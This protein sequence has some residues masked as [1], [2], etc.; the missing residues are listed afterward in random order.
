MTLSKR[1]TAS[2]NPPRIRLCMIRGMIWRA[3][4]APEKFPAPALGGNFRTAAAG[5]VD[6]LVVVGQ[7]GQS[8]DARI[9]T[10]SGHSHYI[11]GEVACPS[12]SFAGAGRRGGDRGGHS[13]RGR[14]AVDGPARRRTKPARVVIDPNGRLPAHARVLRADGIRTLVVITARG[15]RLPERR[16]THC[17]CQRRT[18][19]SPAAIIAAL[20]DR[21]FRRILVEGGAERSRAFLLPAVSTGCISWSPPSS[22]AR[23]DRASPCLPYSGSRRHGGHARA[24]LARSAG[25]SRQIGLG[26]DKRR[27]AAGL[28][29]QRSARCGRPGED[30]DVTD[31]QASSGLAPDMRAPLGQPSSRSRRPTRSLAD[32]IQPGPVGEQRLLDGPIVGPNTQSERPCT[33]E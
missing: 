5:A 26:S 24:C 13:D 17:R 22:S 23:D 2:Q 30:V 33:N 7:C 19:V 1:W 8:I 27:R 11:N 16:R 4:F 32:A 31:A 3:D 9:A 15:A 14:S 29:P 21:G 28:R 25:C 10:P 6:D 12:A 18:A 20:A